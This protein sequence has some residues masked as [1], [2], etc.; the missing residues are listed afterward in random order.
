MR[1]CHSQ[2]YVARGH[3]MRADSAYLIH[4]LN[5]RVDITALKRTSVVT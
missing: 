3:E 2:V 1:F 4:C 5:L